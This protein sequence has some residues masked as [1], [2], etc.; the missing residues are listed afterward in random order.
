M[1]KE[2]KI[3]LIAIEIHLATLFSVFDFETKINPMIYLKKESILINVIPSI[4]KW[5][6][7]T[8]RRDQAIIVSR[9]IFS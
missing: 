1:L 4:E 3:N 2:K 8:N 6:V 7:I 9:L 5:I